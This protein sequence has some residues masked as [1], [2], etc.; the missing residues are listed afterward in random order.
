MPYVGELAALGAAL[1]WS[2]ASMVFQRLGVTID[3]LRLNV[4]KGLVSVSLFILTIRLGGAILPDLDRTAIALIGGS[5]LIGIGLGDTAFF[6][7]LNCLGPRRT[8]LLVTSAAPMTAL[9]AMLTLGEALSMQAIGGIAAIAGGIAWVISDRVVDVQGRGVWWQ[10]VLWGL[11]AAGSQAVGVVLSRAALA[12]TDISPL[13]ST[14]LRIAIGIVPLLLWEVLGIVRY[15]A[16][17]QAWRHI[18]TTPKMI[19]AILI[20]SFFGTYLAIWLQQT[21]IKF[22]PVGIAQ[23]LTSTSPLFVLPLAAWAGDRISGRSL[24][25][26]AIVLLGVAMLF[27]R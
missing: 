13:W 7:A 19:A 17:R 16:E 22:A 2:I 26:V 24:C 4:L 18:L 8:L 6:K 9:L 25:G 3:P 12:D 20:G 21:S 27:L 15:K 23:T 10:G 5:G 14:V 1:V 11:V